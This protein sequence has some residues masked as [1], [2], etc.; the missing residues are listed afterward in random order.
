MGF[1]SGLPGSKWEDRAGPLVHYTVPPPLLARAIRCRRLPSRPP[2]VHT[3][4]LPQSCSH[5]LLPRRHACKQVCKSGRLASTVTLPE[6]LALQVRSSAAGTR[7][8]PA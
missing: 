3:T 2:P 6:V 4:A 7:V 5:M 8:P 1:P